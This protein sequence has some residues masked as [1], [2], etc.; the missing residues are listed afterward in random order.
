MLN[1]FVLEDDF[2]QQSRLENA[3]RRCVEETSVRYKFLE[4]FGKPNQLLESIEEAGNHQFFFLDI[5][6]K[7]EEKKGM[8]IAKEIRARDPYV[9]IVF[10]TTHSEFMPVTY[11][12]RVSALD[13]IDK[14]ININK[15]GTGKSTFSYNFSKW[16][17]S[18]KHKKV[19]LID[20]DSSCSLTYSFKELGTSSIHDVFKGGAFKIYPVD[21]KLD[22]IKGSEFL[23]DED[24]ELRKKQNNCLILFMWFAD[25]IDVLSKYDYVVI[26]THNDASL[27]TSNFIA[28][29]DAV[30][31]VSEPSRNGYRAWLELQETIS[32]LKSE[33]VDI[34]TRRSYIQAA[35]YLIGN[36][37]EH[38]GSS[39]REFLDIIADDSGLLGVIPKKELLAKSLLSDW[40]P[41]TISSKSLNAMPLASGALI[42]LKQEFSLL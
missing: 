11:R 9:V 27:V 2:F 28:V 40:K 7:G 26:D 10:V 23:T 35:P 13:F 8:E 25:N 5:E 34:M 36:K 30:I 22:F 21:K 4:V 16:L 14:G 1:I 37:I 24:L 15:G 3:I 41:L 38:I 29:A 32:R 33:V 39:S 17:S 19:L 12:Y 6:I 31:G 42:T 20:G 18:I